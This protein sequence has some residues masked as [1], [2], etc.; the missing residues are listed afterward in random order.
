MKRIKLKKLH[1]VA[2]VLVLS[3]A[4]IAAAGG[5]LA[6]FTDD[7][8]ITNV[9]TAGN[10]YIDLTEAAVKDDGTGN[11]IEDPD[12]PRVHGVALDSVEKAEHNYGMLYPGKVIHKD[13]TIQNTGDDPAYIA[14]KI[15]ITDGNGDIN[16]LYGFENSEYI[17][18]E[19]LLTGGL[20]GEVVH[21]GKWKNFENAYYNDNFAMV[22]VPDA[23]NG[24]Y[25]FY[26]FLLDQ[27]EKDEKIVLFDTMTIFSDFGTEQ[28]QELEGLEITVQAFAVQT[29][30]FENVYF[31]MTRAFP[32]HFG[33]LTQ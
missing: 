12:Q 31:A 26:I 29:F 20:L 2:I 22:Q 3:V 10:V 14:A 27:C 6:Y 11:L 4:M 1:I 5:T 7:R 18:I 28:M 8:E 24:V 16:K 19:L 25:E 33:K 13:P 21:V 23:A 9:F 15:I 30:G 32:D 17:D